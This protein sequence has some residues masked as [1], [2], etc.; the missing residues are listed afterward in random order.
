MKST[1]A[2]DVAAEMAIV[3]AVLQ[4][5]KMC[6][7]ACTAAIEMLAVSSPLSSS[8]DSTKDRDVV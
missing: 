1:I 8:I 7:K 6:N 2:T 3:S 5:C 4:H